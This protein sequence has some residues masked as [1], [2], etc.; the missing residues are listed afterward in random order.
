[1]SDEP[2]GWEGWLAVCGLKREAAIWG[3]R[4][5]VGGGRSDLLTHRLEEAVATERPTGLISFGVCGALAADLGV[6]AV[7][8]GETVTAPD[9]RTYACGP[10]AMQRL[11]AT[12]AKPTRIAGSDH[13]AADPA[14][15]QALAERGDAVDMESHVAARAAAAHGLPLAVLR[16]V[17]DAAGHDLPPAAIAGMRA[18][19]GVDVC[20]V[21]MGL[22]REPRQLPAL[23]RLGRDSGRAFAALAQAR[24][25]LAGSAVRTP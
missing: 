5:V 19:G 24:L 23:V 1:M 2:A 15:K 12:G 13:V 14:S 25:V 9:G 20:A 8:V 7:I 18:D 22:A 4:A 6:G 11:A 17:S 3:G 21:L 16:V 10:P